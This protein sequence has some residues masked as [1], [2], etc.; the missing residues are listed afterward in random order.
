[1]KK[2]LVILILIG[3]ITILFINFSLS[4]HSNTIKQEIYKGAIVGKIYHDFYLDNGQYTVEPNPNVEVLI[5][6]YV[7][8]IP[9]LSSPLIAKV[10][11]NREGNFAVHVPDGEYAIFFA[12]PS[13]EGLEIVLVQNGETKYVQIKAQYTDL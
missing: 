13:T 5:Y 12:G 9:V 6:S 11:T 7:E 10:T 1:M 4:K 8:A 3:G 2:I